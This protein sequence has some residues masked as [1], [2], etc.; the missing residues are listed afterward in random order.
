LRL[1]YLFSVY[2]LFALALIARYLWLGWNA[3]KGKAPELTDPSQ[4]RD[5]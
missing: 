3:I 2:V 5:E 4:L 1:D